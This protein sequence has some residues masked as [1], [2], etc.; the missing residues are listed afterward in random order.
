[1]RTPLEPASRF[2]FDAGALC[3][4][5]AN[6]LSSRLGGTRRERLGE[7]RDLLAWGRAAGC[8]TAAAGARLRRRSAR[9]P[10][11]A[12]AELRRARRVRERLYRLFSRLAAGASPGA[13]DL[14]GFERD[15]AGALRRLRLR[16]GAGGAS[17]V[18]SWDGE[19]HLERPLW[20]VLRSAAEL[21]ASP[22]AARVRE[23]AGTDC[24]W[25][26]LD[27]SHAARRR[28]CDMRTC[29][30]RAKATRHYRR[31]RAAPPREP[32]HQPED[33]CEP[34]GVAPG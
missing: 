13:G 23:C 22:A 33:G 20:P 32:L 16:P 26:F 14:A 4:D 10:A 11:R 17:W 28:W 15:L 5:F 31:R 2:A 29:G 1:M 6:T 21:L 3:L 25:L 19:D 34:G 12:A 9:E 7:Y 24:S 8:L 30:N 27:R 18:W